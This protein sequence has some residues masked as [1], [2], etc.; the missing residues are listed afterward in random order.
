[1]PM[2]RMRPSNVS[3]LSEKPHAIIT[4]KVPISEMGTAT[5][6]IIVARQLCNDRKTTRITNNRASNRVR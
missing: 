2:A 5:I 3:M 4:A 6:G 1:M